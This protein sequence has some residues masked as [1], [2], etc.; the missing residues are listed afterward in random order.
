M[1][2]A[3]LFSVIVI[4]VTCNILLFGDHYRG[5]HEDDASNQKDEVNRQE[6]ERS[7]NRPMIESFIIS[8][9]SELEDQ[10]LYQ[11]E[12]LVRLLLLDFLN[13]GFFQP[14]SVEFHDRCVE[15]LL[16]LAKPEEIKTQI[17]VIF[18]DVTSIEKH[19]S[20]FV[21]KGKTR[22]VVLGGTRFVKSDY[23]GD[24]CGVVI[25]TISE[26]FLLHLG[27]KP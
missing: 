12:S 18:K 13:S 15:R 24:D 16:I 23:N 2:K 1:M 25:N 27:I 14:L 20:V 4:S 5:K 26:G 6:C 10:K 8:G 17:N 9:S 7:L 11:V 22:Y 19:Q 21:S 3:I